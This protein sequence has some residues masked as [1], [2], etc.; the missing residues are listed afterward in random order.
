[1]SALMINKIV[2]KGNMYILKHRFVKKIEVL[3]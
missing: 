1:M 2:I 3:K